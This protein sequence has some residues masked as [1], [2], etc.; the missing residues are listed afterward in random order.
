MDGA[1]DLWGEL[2]NNL[3]AVRQSDELDTATHIVAEQIYS[4]IMNAYDDT[5]DKM[6]VRA[7]S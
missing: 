5:L 2:Q 6:N 3:F 1:K 7:D 4:K